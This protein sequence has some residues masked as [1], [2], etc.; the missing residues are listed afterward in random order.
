MQEPQTPPAPPTP[1]TPAA[2]GTP[3]A[4]GGGFTITGANPADLYAALRAQ[5]RVLG[6]QLERLEDERGTLVGR[7]AE[8][9]AAGVERQGLE[10]R[11]VNVDQ[12]IVEVSQQLAATDREVARVAGIPGA[13]VEPPPPPD[14]DGPAE[15]VAIIGVAF[16]TLVL[17]PLAIAHARRV[18]RRTAKSVIALPAE[19]AERFMRLEQ[20]VESVAIE[21]ERISEGQRFV[22]KVMAEGRRAEGT[23]VAALGAGPAEPVQVK[24]AQPEPAYRGPR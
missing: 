7:I 18:W 6:E 5:R 24:A 13:A 8:R 4:V 11:I 3:T 1:P 9:P 2:P 12:R 22:T 15:A 10:Q 20:T 21:V 16:T 14:T 19:L 17:F 23:N